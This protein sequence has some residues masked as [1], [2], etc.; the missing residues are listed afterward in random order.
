MNFKCLALNFGR[1]EE[2]LSRC[3]R[4][5][6]HAVMQCYGSNYTQ[7][8]QAYC[9]DIQHLQLNQVDHIFLL[10]Q[11]DHNPLFCHLVFNT[12]IPETPYAHAEA[13]PCSIVGESNSWV[14]SKQK[15]TMNI[16]MGWWMQSCNMVAC[17]SYSV[18][19][20]PWGECNQTCGGGIQSRCKAFSLHFLLSPSF[21]FGG[22]MCWIGLCVVHEECSCQ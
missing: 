21:S 13:D 16:Q 1:I 17:R 18:F 19:E 15:Q 8:D 20:G 3:E 4:G 14:F 9:T 7:V 11:I 22:G 10:S 2:V 5:G 6:Q 12:H